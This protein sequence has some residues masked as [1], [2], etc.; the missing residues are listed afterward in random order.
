MSFVLKG[1]SSAA[2]VR[3]MQSKCSLANQYVRNIHNLHRINQK[4]VLTRQLP[5][6][7]NE[8]SNQKQCI[9]R[10]F[11]SNDLDKNSNCPRTITEAV[12]SSVE[13]GHVHVKMHLSY[14]C[15][16]CN[17]RNNKTI[18]K[19][20]YTHGVVIVR[21]DKCLNNHLIADN[22]QWFQDL[23]G[24]RNIEEILAAKGEKVQRLEYGEFVNTAKKEDLDKIKTDSSTSVADNEQE[25]VKLIEGFTKKAQNIKEKLGKF[26]QLKK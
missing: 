26:L 15:K 12:E 4:V 9:N 24:K 11:Y 18:S 25:E 6:I 3:L 22:L 13:I 1:V 20:A 21:C 7:G 14:T 8:N 2:I 10:R 19:V 5:N 23:E 16:V 17:T